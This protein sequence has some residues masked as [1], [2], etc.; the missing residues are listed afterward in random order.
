MPTD[1]IMN[2]AWPA[3]ENISPAL[4]RYRYGTTEIYSNSNDS[5][6]AYFSGFRIEDN[7]YHFIV[8]LYDERKKKYELCV[9]CHLN[10]EIFKKNIPGFKCLLATS[11]RYYYSIPLC[12]NGVEENKNFY[13]NIECD[14]NNVIKL[15]E[16][17]YGRE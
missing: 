9:G 11:Q 1:I 3:G 14:G 13:L 4:D 17:D 7:I 8:T 12:G 5:G 10:A 2:D 16:V 6:G 15:I